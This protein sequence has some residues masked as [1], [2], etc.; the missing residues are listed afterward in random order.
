M[1]D[2]EFFPPQPVLGVGWTHPVLITETKPLGTT[3][4]PGVEPPPSRTVPDEPAKLDPDKFAPNRYAAAWQCPG[5]GTW[6]SYF[7][8]SCACQTHR[9]SSASTTIKLHPSPTS[10]MP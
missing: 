1:S 6:Y 8:S 3:G 9:W 7:V 4:S 2:Y 5:C 10:E